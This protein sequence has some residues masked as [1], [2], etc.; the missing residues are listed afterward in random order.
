MRTKKF[1][2]PL[3]CEMLERYLMIRQLYPQWFKNL[4]YKEPDLQA[5]IDSGYIVPLPER[6]DGK[7]VIFSNAEKFDPY[8]FTAAHMVKIHSLVTET[9]MDDELN[10]VNGYVYVNDVAGFQ[11]GHISLWSLKDIRNIVRCIQNSSPMRHKE[12]HLLNVTGGLAKMVEFSISVMTDK[13]RKRTFVDKSLQ[14]L[15][16]KIDPKILPREYGGVM[17]M[18]EMIDKFKLKLKE[19]RDRLLALDEMHIEID[20]NNC[21]LITEMNEE[22]GMGIEGSFKKLQVD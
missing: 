14:D 18:A 13:L 3:A 1:S 4:D 5:L 7:L 12:N 20:E 11:M 19:N 21:Q 15:H 10:Q 16:D 6:H 22:L 9:L 17:P 2:V 8:K